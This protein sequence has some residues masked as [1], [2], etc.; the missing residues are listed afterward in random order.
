MKWAFL[1]NLL[2]CI[3]T[4]YANDHGDDATDHCADL[5]CGRIHK[6]NSDKICSED[7]HIDK[8]KEK[9]EN[10]PL[11]SNL[12]LCCEKHAYM[13]KYED[14]CSNVRVFDI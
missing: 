3:Y 7:S 2:L 13:Y 4:I 11:D 10:E 14:S 6:F 9:E 1:I 12:K 5:K 8:L